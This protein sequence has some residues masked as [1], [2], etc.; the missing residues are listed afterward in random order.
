MKRIIM[1][2]GERQT[3][4]FERRSET[5]VYGMAVLLLGL[6]AVAPGAWGAAHFQQ[7]ASFGSAAAAGQRPYVGLVQGSD[8]ALYGTTLQG[9]GD[10]MGT[11]FKVCRAGNGYTVL[12]QFSASGGDGQSPMALVQGVDGAL[13]GTTSIGGTNKAGT[14]FKMNRD[15]SG[16]TLLHQFGSVG[17]DGQNAQAGL[18][19]ASDGA[20]YGTTFFGGSN[21][22]G[23]VF[24]LSTNGS[25]YSI[26]HHFSS[27]DSD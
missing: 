18:M 11:V 7:V 14:V 15:G 6:S 9:G 17:S 19:Q 8:G 1:S 10:N 25:A 3:T 4:R 13:Y 23:I 12:H 21:D 20:L 26:L 16:Y 5:R 27:S 24:K 22:L 2:I